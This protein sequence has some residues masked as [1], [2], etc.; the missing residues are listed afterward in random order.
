MR[1]I[2]GLILM[3]PPYT[4]RVVIAMMAKY[5]VTLRYRCL[6]LRH[7]Y[8]YHD[9]S[10]QPPLRHEAGAAAAARVEVA[11]SRRHTPP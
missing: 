5:K 9:T 2:R 7:G 8:L 6:V 10:H 1:A 3:P 4:A 11:T